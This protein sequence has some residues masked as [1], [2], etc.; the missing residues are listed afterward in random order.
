MEHR[1]PPEYVQ[2]QINTDVVPFQTA[3]ILP[4]DQMVQISGGGAWKSLE[5]YPDPDVTILLE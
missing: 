3:R 1:Y 4:Q 5:I 2:L